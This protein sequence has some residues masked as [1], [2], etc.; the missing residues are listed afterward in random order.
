MN[1]N[2]D[3]AIVTGFGDKG[4][5]KLK[6]KLDA[7]LNPRSSKT[8]PSAP[9]YRALQHPETVA[10]RVGKE[11]EKIPSDD[12]LLI[13]HSYGALIALVVACRLKLHNVLKLVLIDGPLSPDIEVVPSRFAHRLFSRH[14]DY[15]VKLAEECEWI[16]EGLDTSK[17][18]TIGS[19]ID[20]IV[21]PEAK[22]L[23]GAF[24]TVQMRSDEDAQDMDFS[25]G[26]GIN[27]VLPKKYATHRLDHKV[28]II[29]DLIKRSIPAPA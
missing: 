28:D 11:V 1:R 24:D 13:G 12:L 8:I 25:T 14:Y 21:P 10:A 3:L 29:A 6:T 15:R 23:K 5:D 17:I 16:L 18:I 9:W 2:I 19:R 20:R 22:R 27:I 4:I 7:E 26:K